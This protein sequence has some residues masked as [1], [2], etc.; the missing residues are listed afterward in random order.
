M[1]QALQR[2][3]CSQR[4]ASML[5]ALLF[6][7]LCTMV[8]ASILMAAASNA[9]KYRSNLEEHQQYLTLSS[10]VSLLC[11][12]L[13]R[14]EYRGQYNYWEV[15]VTIPPE[16][17]GGEA[18]T[19]TTRHFRWQPGHYTSQLTAML[20][21]DFD[22]I[23]YKEA[24]KQLAGSDIQNESTGAPSTPPKEFRHSLTVTP[25]TDTVL[26]H[27]VD[28]ELRV[29]TATYAMY[30]T[31]TLDG[32]TMEAELT[33]ISTSAPSL[34]ASMTP[35]GATDVQQTNNAMEWKIGWITTGQEE[36][37]DTP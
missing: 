22:A 2:K 4:G 5:L 35:L 28:V 10:T 37:E 27:P 3:L 36:E 25:S 14:A 6:L 12:E 15:T 30:L 16:T 23:F 34:P 8:A 7:V 19:I 13:N 9:G 33:P 32:Y 21:S 31:A 29:D 20:L 26:D 11:D 24:Q 17:E 18:T 1:R